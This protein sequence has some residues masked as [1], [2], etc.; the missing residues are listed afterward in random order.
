MP[1]SDD[2]LRLLD[3]LRD[4]PAWPGADGL[5]LQDIMAARR[6][7]CRGRT[8]PAKKT[9]PPLEACRLARWLVSFGSV[10]GWYPVGEFLVVDAGTAIE[11]A[12]EVFGPGEAYRAEQIPWDAAPLSGANRFATRNPP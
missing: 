5:T 6:E 4:E 7:A 9:P 1:D 12:I 8:M 2:P 3:D 10:S 11:R